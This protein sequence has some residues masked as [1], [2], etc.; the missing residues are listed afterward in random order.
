MP[1]DDLES[2]P[3]PVRR[4]RVQSVDLYEVK[5]SELDIL[6]KGT[7]ADLQ[8]NFAVFLLSIAASAVMALATATFKYHAV[9]TAFVVVATVGVL[10]GIYLLI[11]WSRNRSSSR[12]VCIAIR[13]RMGETV[14]KKIESSHEEPDSGTIS[15]GSKPPVEPSF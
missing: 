8:L 15:P 5:D 1:S 13:L 2:T 3:L 9:Q 12:D 4:A 10:M 6:E 11:A 14:S 7:P